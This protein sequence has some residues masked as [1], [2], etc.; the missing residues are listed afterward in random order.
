MGL[1]KITSVA[2][3]LDQIAEM[4]EGGALRDARGLLHVVGDDDDGVVLL[5]LVDQLLDMGRGDRIER[6]ARLVHQDDLGLTAM[7]R[8]MHSRCCWPPDRPVPGSCS[9]S[10]TSSNSPARFRLEAT[11]LVQLGLA[12]GQAMDA[13]AVGDVLEDRLGERVRLLEHHADA[14][15]QLHHVEE[16]S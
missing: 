6:R 4:E 10:F 9:R 16:R 14:G 7:A 8:A 11:I 15:P 13:R 5:Q 2:A 12:L 1:L 3:F